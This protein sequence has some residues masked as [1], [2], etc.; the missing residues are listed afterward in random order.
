MKQKKIYF[1]VMLALIGCALIFSSAVQAYDVYQWRGLNRN[2]V[3]QETGLLR[4]WPA[5][6]PKMLWFTSGIGNGY[7][8]PVVVNGKI[9]ITGVKAEKEYLTALDLSGHK[10]WSVMYGNAFSGQYNGS[11]TTPTV[12]NGKLYVVSGEGE[13]ACINAKN[14]KI[15]WK[16]NGKNIFRAEPG[17]WGTAESPL[18]IDNKVIYTPG[19]EKTTM[20]ALNSENGSTTWQSPSLDDAAAFVSPLLI[21]HNGKRQ[22]ISVISTYIFGTNPDTGKIM[23]KVNYK[24]I[25]SWGFRNVLNTNTPIYKDGRIFITS[26]YDHGGLMLKLNQDATKANIIREISDFDTHHGGTVL[27]DGY[28]YGSNW[29]N[30]QKGN[31][32]SV[33][34]KTGKKEYEIKWGGKGSIISAE[35]MLYVYEELRGTLGLLKATPK[36]FNIISSFK[37]RKG[38]SQHWCH[39]IISDGRLYIR[40]G[41]VIMA[42]DIT[43]K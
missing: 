37:I 32:V 1:A 25:G 2:G 16:V 42:Y 20:V 34:W 30:N 19:G 6:G 11:R 43:V 14:G 23:W 40:R 10:L 17:K 31:W 28:L 3:Y 24:Q 8:S 21:K 41:K 38:N 12:V 39:P 9:Y 33:N 4:K 5:K 26:G 7:S 13:I 35:G 36:G 15:V 18:V 27:V 22:I 29:L